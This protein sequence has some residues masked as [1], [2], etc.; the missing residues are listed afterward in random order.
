MQEEP[1]EESSSKQQP[2]PP[3]QIRASSHVEMASARKP[4][5]TNQDLTPGLGP[6]EELAFLYFLLVCT[7]LS[8]EMGS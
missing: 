3:P 2:D 8:A 4:A 1:G 5:P 6:I 7:K